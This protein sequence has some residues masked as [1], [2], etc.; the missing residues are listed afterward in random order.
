M[1]LTQFKKNLTSVLTTAKCD[2]AI[3]IRDTAYRDAIIQ[4]ALDPSVRSIEFLPVDTRKPRVAMNG[5][6]LV[7]DD[8]RYFIDI[9]RVSAP[10]HEEDDSYFTELLRDQNIEILKVSSNTL[11]IEPLFSNCREVWRYQRHH[12]P[13]SDRMQ[14]MWCL[15]E[16]GPQTLAQMEERISPSADLAPSVCALACA[17][18]LEMQLSE[19]PLG[20]WTVIRERR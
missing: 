16:E 8:G 2:V 13:I 10:K 1:R 12:V 19:T 4:A 9:E 14:I 17:D 6:I 20:P 7:R 18:L 3:P 5:I 11:R 15:T